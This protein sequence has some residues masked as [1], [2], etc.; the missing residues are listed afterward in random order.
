MYNMAL[1]KN[2]QQW[3][4]C[5]EIKPNITWLVYLHLNHRLMSF[6]N[7]DIFSIYMLSRN[8]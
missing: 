1:A 3:L 7:K 4:I 6:T 8:E 2:N 5:H